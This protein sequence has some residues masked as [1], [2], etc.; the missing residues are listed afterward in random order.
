MRNLLLYLMLVA[1][2]PVQAQTGNDHSGLRGDPE[3]I[4]EAEAMVAAMGGI[5]IWAQLK[6]VHFVHEWD[7]FNRPDR[8]L[9]NE[10]LELTAPRAW[11]TM[12]SEMYS[13]LRAYS[14]EHRYWNVVNGE[15]AYASDESFANAMERAPFSIY[16]LARAIA[17]GDEYFEV[18]FGEGE[19][20]GSRRLEFR[21]PEGYLGGWI[22]LNARKE[23][24]LWATTQYTYIFGPLKRFGNLRVPNWAITGEGA[25]RY[26]MVSLKGSGEIPDS[27]LFVPPAE[28]VD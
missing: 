25:V 14:P 27:S 16:R 10:I 18:T 13:R 20:R 2:W 11:V 21:N 6:S 22:I 19:F 3:A 12:E 28:F 23:P 24:V 17:I 5:K 8:Y 15:F 9:E 4:A 7:I 1:A 26:E